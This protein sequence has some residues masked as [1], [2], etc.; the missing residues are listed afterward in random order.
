MLL[1]LLKGPACE[2]ST[3]QFGQSPYSVAVK[4]GARLHMNWVQGVRTYDLFTIKSMLIGDINAAMHSTP[5]H[6]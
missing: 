1:E 3:C 4:S 2:L 5:F 6:L